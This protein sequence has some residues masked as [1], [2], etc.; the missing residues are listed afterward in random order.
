MAKRNGLGRGLDALLS[1]NAEGA[2][3]QGTTL[4]LSEIMPNPKQP[5]RRFDPESLRELSEN[6]SA[7]GLIQPIVVRPKMMGGYEIVAGERRWR[8]CRMAG[9]ESIPVIIR[10]LS[11]TETMELAMIENLQ[12]EDLNPVEEARGYEALIKQYG[13]TQEQ[14]AKRVGKSR[15]AVANS[16]RLL[17]LGDILPLLE[18]GAVS[19][20]HGRALLSIKDKSLRMKALEMIKKGATVRDIER[21]SKETQEKKPEPTKQPSAQEKQSDSR[22]PYYNEVELA[23]KEELGRRVRIDAAGKKGTLCIDFYNEEDLANLIEWLFTK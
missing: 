5:R 8:A 7:H 23:L 22:P 9:L 10:E 20:G 6:I 15:S 16:L 14:V 19:A 21:L 4:G 3:E 11:D 1:D 18:N 2:A 13:M 17:E 12:R